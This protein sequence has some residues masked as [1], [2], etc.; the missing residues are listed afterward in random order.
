MMLKRFH[1]LAL[2]LISVTMSLSAETKDPQAFLP[3]GGI[4]VIC[5]VV[6]LSSSAGGQT[7]HRF[8]RGAGR[9]ATRKCA[10]GENVPEP[11][12]ARDSAKGHPHRYWQARNECSLLAPPCENQ[13]AHAAR[14]GQ[15]AG[16]SCGPTRHPPPTQKRS[17]LLLCAR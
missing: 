8:A 4:Y 6:K 14:G 9:H 12:D 11:A 13:R 2:W 1:L 10:A 7:F 17:R 15:S 16:V 3:P 5:D